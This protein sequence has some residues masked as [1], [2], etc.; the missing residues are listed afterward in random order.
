M[1]GSNDAPL[2]SCRVFDAPAMLWS[3]AATPGPRRSNVASSKKS[4]I[5]RGDRVQYHLSE[6]FL[7]RE[8]SWRQ[9]T[10]TNVRDADAEMVNI[11][12]CS[13][14]CGV[15]LWRPLPPFSFISLVSQEKFVL[16]L[17]NICIPTAQ[18]F[19]SSRPSPSFLSEIFAR[20][21]LRVV[22]FQQ[23]S[24]HILS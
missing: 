13:C 17:F 14:V 10:A 1:C 2:L 5:L 16:Y 22:L 11:S 6:F 18:I 20:S 7:P 23:T 8:G 19:N 21:S 24:Q 4:I 15:A 12:T 9:T 3:A